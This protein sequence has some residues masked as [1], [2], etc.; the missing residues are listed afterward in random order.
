MIKVDFALDWINIESGK[1]L[2]RQGD[3][4]DGVFVVLSGRLRAAI[5]KSGNAGK[6]ELVD[7][8]IHGNMVGLVDVV[9]ATNRDAIYWGFSSGFLEQVL[10]GSAK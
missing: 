6:K 8:Y 10:Q 9:T 4:A 3:S 5:A 7:E 1:A 2:Y